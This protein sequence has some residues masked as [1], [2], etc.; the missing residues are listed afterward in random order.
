MATDS[1]KDTTDTPN[2]EAGAHTA[3]L[4]PARSRGTVQQAVN[5][6]LDERY[7]T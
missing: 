5:K 2:M 3:S 4:H 1:M 6:T 7:F